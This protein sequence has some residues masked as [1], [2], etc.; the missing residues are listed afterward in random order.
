MSFRRVSPGVP[1]LRC[2][3]S[4]RAKAGMR[5]YN[6]NTRRLIGLILALGCALPPAAHA[7]EAPRGAP[8]AVVNGQ[9]VYSNDL[10]PSPEL[11]KR[12]GT[13]LSQDQYE[14]WL[15]SHRDKQLS[16][17][18]WQGVL[19][20]YI[21]S[22]Q[23]KVAEQEVDVVSEV[24]HKGREEKMKEGEAARAQLQQDLKSPVLTAQT[25]AQ[26]T[27]ELALLE[28]RL[29][30]DRALFSPPNEQ[31]K[32]TVRA[33][34]RE[35]ARNTVLQ[36]KISKALYQQYGG[37]VI[38]R[39]DVFEPID[40]YRRYLEEQEAR[41]TFQITDLKLRASFYQYY[42]AVHT[43]VDDLRVQFYFEKPWWLRTKQELKQFGV[44]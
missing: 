11:L 31:A 27:R 19:E 12:A 26:L 25:R 29:A 37:K 21:A 38:E 44:Q 16:W 20:S 34:E 43:P 42:T 41:K 15:A 10:N 35:L 14:I 39:H 18:V 22:H 24:M 32:Q 8:V 5:G 30:E 3:F 13:R 7:A 33:A 2:S 9:T 6:I 1:L 28:R 23:L 17:R 36:W 4:L 40:A